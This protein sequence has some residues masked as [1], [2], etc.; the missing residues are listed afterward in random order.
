M[1]TKTTQNYSQEKASIFTGETHRPTNTLNLHLVL[2]LI[3]NK[4]ETYQFD[5]WRSVKDNIKRLRLGLYF[6]QVNTE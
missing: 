3:Q 1:K 4:T 6:F 5:R 2:H